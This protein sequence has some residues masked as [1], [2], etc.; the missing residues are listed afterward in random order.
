MFFFSVGCFHLTFN[1]VRKYKYSKVWLIPT[2]GDLGF[3]FKLAPVPILSS[4]RFA[5][6]ERGSECVLLVK[7]ACLGATKKIPRQ[8]IGRHKIE[9]VNESTVWLKVLYLYLGGVDIIYWHESCIYALL[10]SLR[11]SI[12]DALISGAEYPFFSI[13]EHTQI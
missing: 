4:H 10:R 6:G 12:G 2:S 3:W 5:G 11:Q 13:P 7:S 1:M 9:L 8:Q